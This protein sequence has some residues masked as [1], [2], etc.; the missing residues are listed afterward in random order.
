MH[1]AVVRARP[2]IGIHRVRLGILAEDVVV[3][4]GTGRLHGPQGGTLNLVCKEAFA[5]QPARLGGGLLL[6]VLF[7]QG[8]EDVGQGFVERA[9]LVAVVQAA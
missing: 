5:D 8:A 9:G 6:G 4:R 3:V 7:H 1:P 2:Y